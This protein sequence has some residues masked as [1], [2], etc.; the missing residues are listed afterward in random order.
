MFGKSV[1]IWRIVL[2]ISCLFILVTAQA[3]ICPSCRQN[4]YDGENCTNPE[5][6]SNQACAVGAA[7]PSSPPGDLY[8]QLLALA[9][10]QQ[11]GFN[12][13]PSSDAIDYYSD[14]DVE[15]PSQYT[16]SFYD[17]CVIPEDQLPE[18]IRTLFQHSTNGEEGIVPDLSHSYATARKKDSGYSKIIRPKDMG[19]A[20]FIRELLK[21]RDNQLLVRFNFV[22]GGR[23]HTTHLAIEI[24]ADG[25]ILVL[26]DAE[27]YWNEVNVASVTEI[28]SFLLNG[29]NEST[30]SLEFLTLNAEPENQ[31]KKTKSSDPNDYKVVKDDEPEDDASDS[32]KDDELKSAQ[33]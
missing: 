27:G 31:R 14:Y 11:G 19:I 10:D 5:C 7:K 18:W 21:A 33:E 17:P 29:F 26:S 32:K 12:G 9:L 23:K 1:R 4:T 8:I 13:S 22:E 24:D 2:C 20:P 25:H 30:D 16:G 3:M 28:L 15:Q 6:F